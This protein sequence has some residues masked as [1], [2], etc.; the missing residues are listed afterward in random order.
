MTIVCPADPAT[1]RPAAYKERAFLLE[2]GVFGRR[3]P[4]ASLLTV[5]AACNCLQHLGAPV[6]TL[7]AMQSLQGAKPTTPAEIRSLAPPNALQGVGDGRDAE[8]ERDMDA[9]EGQLPP[10]AATSA[11]PSSTAVGGSSLPREQG[12]SQVP[13]CPS[14]A[15]PH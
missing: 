3:P 5:Q 1:M 6:S 9:P 12:A 11:Q 8:V 7:A 2:N 14:N 10:M 4:R 15:E 13:R